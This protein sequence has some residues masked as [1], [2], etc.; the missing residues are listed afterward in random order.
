[1]G[2]KINY[3]GTNYGNDWYNK[4]KVGDI[5]FSQYNYNSIHVNFYVVVKTTDR[6]VWL[7]PMDK[8]GMPKK[9]QPEWKVMPGNIIPGKK[10]IRKL[11][12][13][14]MKITDYSYCREWD[15]QPLTEMSD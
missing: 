4:L 10:V 9:W 14:G 2:I 15:G 8:R 5:I 11:R 3:K 7:A 13:R 12:T 1:M 6:S